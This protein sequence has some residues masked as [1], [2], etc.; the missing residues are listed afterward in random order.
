MAR[1]RRRPHGHARIV[2]HRRHPPGRHR[3]HPGG[4]HTRVVRSADAARGGAP[5]PTGPT[6]PGR[7]TRRSQPHKAGDPLAPVTVIVPTNY[8]G[9]TA[10]RLLGG[11]DRSARSSPAPHGV[12]AVT[13]PHRLPPRRAARRRPRSRPP[14]GARCPRP[15]SRPR[16]GG[17]SATQPGRVRPGRRAPRHRAGAGRAPTASCRRSTPPRSTR[18]RR[19]GRRAADVVRVTDAARAQLA[20]EWY[21]ERDLMDAATDAVVARSRRRSPTSARSSCTSHRTSPTRAA[22]PAPRRRRRHAGHR[23]RRHAPA[24]RAPTRASRGRRP[25]R[26]GDRRQTGVR[27]GQLTP[28]RGRV[29]H[30]TRG[31]R[32]PTPTTR[33]ARSCG[34]SSTR[35]ARA[36]RSSAWRCSSAR[37][38]RTPGWCT[39][40]STAA[41]IPHNGAAVRTLARERAR[42]ARC[43]RCSRSPTATSTVT[44]SWRCSR[45]RRCTSAT[46]ARCRRRGGSAS[47]AGPGSCAAPR[48][49]DVSLDRHVAALEG[50]VADEL[51]GH[52]PRPAARVVPARARRRPR[53]LHAFVAELQRRARRGRR[54]RRELARARRVGAAAG[55]RAASRGARRRDGWPEHER[56]G[57]REGRGRARAPRR[58]RRGRALARARRVPAHARAR[59]RRRPRPG[60]SPRRRHARS[61]SVAP[62]ARASTSTAS[63]CAGWPRARSPPASATTRC[64]PTT[65]AAPPAARCALRAAPGRRRPPHVPRRARAPRPSACCSLPRGDLRRTT[66]RMPSRF[67][68]DTVEALRRH[69]PLR[70]RPRARSTADWYTVVPSFTAGIARVEFPATEQEHRLRTLLDHTRAGRR[71]GVARAAHTTDVVLGAALECAR[72]AS[73]PRVHPLRRQPRRASP[74]P[75]RSPTTAWSCR[76]PGSR[77][78]PTRRT[79]TSWSRCSGSRSRSC[80]R[81]ST[82]SRP[83]TAGQPGA[84]DPRHVPRRG[85]RRGPAGAPAPDE[86]WTAADRARLHEIAAARRRRY[87]AQGLTGRRVFWHRDQRAILAELDRFLAED[88]EVRAAHGLSP[89]RHRAPLR[90][91]P[92]PSTRRSSSR[93]PTAARCASAAP[94]TGSTAPPTA[95]L[96]SST[97][98]PARRPRRRRPDWAARLQLPVYAR[99]ARARV[100]RRRHPGRS[101]RTGT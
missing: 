4:C 8:V 45:R 53:D 98:R 37:P 3:E 91:S 82:S 39:S 10:R 94:P 15:C 78:G 61:G 81:R 49:G 9:V 6:P 2:A 34:W 59:A 31:R 47:A 60:R 23:D 73:E 48:S 97:T 79:T 56:A 42:R 46:A 22:A 50:L 96:W 68:L 69:A 93:C 58:A 95:T 89:H 18:S 43:S 66:E 70:R 41:G 14:G 62:R 44:T 12:A 87:E 72:G 33:C 57:G 67:V 24:S 92:A 1:G 71:R 27:P 80:P 35:C 76:P 36:C 13:L 51:A 52:R 30:G 55:G 101:P 40:S 83:S 5:P 88:A 29:V 17:C 84:R 63:S 16:C 28:V 25:P 32:R 38:S 20:A 74:C 26:L 99:A 65:T 85:A 54:G 90:A 100:R 75:A 64:S 77:R 11:G 86:A 21:D 19:T 7:C